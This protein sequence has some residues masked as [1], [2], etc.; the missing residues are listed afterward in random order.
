MVNLFE[1]TIN[2]FHS[3]PYDGLSQQSVRLVLW[4]EIEAVRSGNFDS[5]IKEAA[6]LID[7][8]MV[9][10]AASKLKGWTEYLE[11]ANL[12]GFASLSC[13]PGDIS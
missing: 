4:E 8:G 11:D 1:S 12:L 5:R 3:H 9:N 7:K 13:A 2:D 6:E 10:D